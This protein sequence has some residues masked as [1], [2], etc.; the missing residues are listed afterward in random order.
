MAERT[1]AGHRVLAV[2]SNYGVEQDELLVP[3]EHLRNSGAEVDVA[4]VS[5]EPV[6]SLVS[7]RDPGKVIDPSLGVDEV[8]PAAYDLLF[9]PGGTVNADSLRLNDSVGELVRAF[10]SSGRPVASICHGPWVLVEAA[11]VRD[12]T[13]TSYPSLETDI[14]NAGGDWVDKS[15]VRD[16]TG[17]WELVTSRKPS[18][19]RDFLTAVD[20]A[21][22]ATPGRG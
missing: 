2:V 3:V 5:A 18:D 13:L 11:V 9:I 22:M 6:Q 1:P 12:K 17:G 4:A 7:D 16:D 15:V 20:A 21:L 14:R 19:L 10:T 8:D